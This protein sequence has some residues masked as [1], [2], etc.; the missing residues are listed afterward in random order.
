[1]DDNYS[2]QATDAF[3]RAGHDYLNYAVSAQQ[4]LMQLGMNLLH[5]EIAAGQRIAGSRDLGQAVTVWT[6]LMK[7]TVED[8]SG[9][10]TRLLDRASSVGTKIAQNA[11]EA[12][13]AAAER[14]KQTGE[15]V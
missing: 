10:T 14:A 3:R 15:N 1:M 2:E 4:E 11:Q 5:R 8:F 13:R 12:F 6:D 9:T 7:Q